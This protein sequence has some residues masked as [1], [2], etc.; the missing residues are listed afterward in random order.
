MAY[1][2][3]SM[4][5][6]HVSGCRSESEC[7]TL[8]A[9]L[10]DMTDDASLVGTNQQHEIPSTTM[11]INT[12]YQSSAMTEALFRALS[13]GINM[14]SCALYMRIHGMDTAA[15]VHTR[16]VYHEHPTL[17]ML[18]RAIDDLQPTNVTR[19]HLDDLERESGMLCHVATSRQPFDYVLGQAPPIGAGFKP[20]CLLSGARVD[21]EIIPAA[22]ENN[23]DVDK[24]RTE[25][26]IAFTTPIFILHIYKGTPTTVCDAYQ[27]I[28]HSLMIV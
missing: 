7:M 8:N 2:T 4:K 5:F 12:S 3:S 24:I 25:Y 13:S 1:K 19:R 28:I 22:N 11:D 10:H 6:R 20:I 16:M 14:R 15:I 21:Q 9:R 26:E 27:I 23:P 17:S 18:F